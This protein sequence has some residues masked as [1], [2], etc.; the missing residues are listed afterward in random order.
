[1]TKEKYIQGKHSSTGETVKPITYVSPLG[2]VLKVTD[3]LLS[4]DTYT[5]TFGIA[6][7]G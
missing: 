2:S 6:A 7:N 3:N 5:T 4:N 1:M